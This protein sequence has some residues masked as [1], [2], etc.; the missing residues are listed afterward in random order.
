MQSHS[1]KST[2]FKSQSIDSGKPLTTRFPKLCST[3]TT[4]MRMRLLSTWW[5]FV[6]KRHQPGTLHSKRLSLA[7]LFQSEPGVVDNPATRWLE[8]SEPLEDGIFSQY[9]KSTRSGGPLG[10]LIILVFCWCW[11]ESV[12]YTKV[13]GGYFLFTCFWAESLWNICVFLCLWTRMTNQPCSCKHRK[14]QRHSQQYNL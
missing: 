9:D 7:A 8:I 2:P 10:N 6:A 11:Y 3:Q 5:D 13:L 12:V 4:F 14:P 1:L